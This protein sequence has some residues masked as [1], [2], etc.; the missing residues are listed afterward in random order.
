[1]ANV[2]DFGAVGDG[3]RDDSDSIQHA[4]EQGDGFVEFS[5]GDY[6]ISR[7]MLVDLSKH[8]RC[9]LQGSGGTAKLIMAG[10]GPAIRLI[11]THG[12]SADP[13]SFD[14]M[15][16]QRERMPQ[17]TGIEI[18][19]EHPQADGIAIDGVMQATLTGLLLR[20]LR[21]AVH[22]KNRARNLLINACHI[23]ENTGIGVF[24]DQVNLH[25]AII[26]ASHIS[27]CRLGGIRIENSE[28]R[29]LQITGNDIE[30][31]NNKT[32]AIPDADDIAT[33]EIY[34]DAG[35]HSIREGTICSNTIQATA[36]KNG[37]NIR[38]VGNPEVGDHRTGMFTISGNLIGSQENNIHLSW[39]RGITLTGNYIYS[40]HNRNLLAENCRN[41]LMS[42]NCFGHNPDYKTE[43][44]A[45]GVRFVD[46]VSCNLT[47]DLIEDADAGRHTLKG[48]EPV[49]RMGLL[50]LVRCQRFNLNGVQILNGTPHGISIE[51]GAEILI[52][53][54]T[55]S[56][57]R[58]QPLMQSAIRWHGDGAKNMVSNCLL[59][60]GTAKLSLPD[61]V[62]LQNCLQ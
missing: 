38:F 50:E 52:N 61:H 34:I 11:G 33:A 27:Y 58:A 15:V 51:E 55:I 8:G 1:M 46:C 53:G 31:N 22:L 10:P 20:K 47:G 23:Y 17:I 43:E 37:A 39:A 40:G 60:A 2:R 32:H 19:G 30:Y 6:R 48:V 42:S 3:Q 44:L 9:S 35:E 45:T 49:E 56:E 62:H 5:R 36:S 12:G 13:Q 18:M 41:I 25:Q 54:C 24:L 7:S 16:W 28:I 14:A 21:H 29:N 57:T 26:A 4:I 59:S